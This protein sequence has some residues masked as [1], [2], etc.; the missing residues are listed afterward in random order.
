MCDHHHDINLGFT[1]E[2]FPAGAHMCYVYADEAE[3]RTVISRYI[4]S[5]L[6]AGELVGY[7]ADVEEGLDA[8]L[9]EMGVIL[10]P[11]ASSDRVRLASAHSVYYPDGTFV[12]ERM[13]DGLRGMYLDGIGRGFTGVR[14]TGEMNWALNGVPGAERLIEYEA[15]VNLLVEEY[16]LTA[17]CQYDA[18]RFDGATIYDVLRVHPMMVVHGQIMHNPYYV[19]PREFLKLD[20]GG[21]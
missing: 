10:P 21:P 16:P 12:P 11:E 8:Y 7:F 17:M 4:N 13:L 9:A 19:P 20:Q 18:R 2:R 3:R 15:R 5:G 1:A 6:S 14:A